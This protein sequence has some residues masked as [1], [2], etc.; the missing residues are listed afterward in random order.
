LA[1]IV[2]LVTGVGLAF[3]FE[4]LDNTIK[5]PED[6]KQYLKTPYLGPVPLFTSEKAGN[7]DDGAHQDLVAL[8][9]PKSSASESY[10]GIRTSILF[11]SAESAPQVILVSSAAPKEGKTITA[12]NLGVTMAQANGK[13]IILDCDMRRPSMHRLFG[14]SKDVGVSNLLVG[15]GSIKEAIVHTRI[16]NLDIIPCGPIP[17]NP[18][19]M[20]GSARML[21]LLNGL[22]KLYAHILI[23]SPP[24]TAVTDA[25]VLSRTADGVI[26]VVRTGETARE[27]VKNG[28]AHFGAVGSNILGTVLNGVDMRGN[29]YYYYGEDGQKKKS[30]RTRKKYKDDY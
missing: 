12:A 18:S 4:Y 14:T 16:P 20:L 5:L 10:R 24:S 1:L 28:L 6:V 2:G 9:S 7:P 27:I 3:F 22:R 26:M 19:E 15:G 17:P 21:T 23:D 25:V 11:S 29:G 8:H 30:S 13:T